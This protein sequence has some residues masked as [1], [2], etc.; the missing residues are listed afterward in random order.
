MQSYVTESVKITSVQ[1]KST[2]VLCEKIKHD[3]WHENKV[4]ENKVVPYCETLR[5][6]CTQEHN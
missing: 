5:Y 3:L 6:T 1:K 2:K 4:I